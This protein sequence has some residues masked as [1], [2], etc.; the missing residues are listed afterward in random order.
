[1]INKGYQKIKIKTQLLGEDISFPVLAPINKIKEKVKDKIDSGE[2]NLGEEVVK[3]SYT[4][5]IPQT[6]RTKLK[7]NKKMSL[8]ER[9]LYLISEKSYCTSMSVWV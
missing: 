4:L 2:I 5:H 3:T 9:F 1:M 8:L 7:Q 6:K